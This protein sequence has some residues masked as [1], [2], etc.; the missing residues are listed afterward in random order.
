[1]TDPDYKAFEDLVKASLVLF[2]MLEMTNYWTVQTRKHNP[3][4]GA[5]EVIELTITRSKIIPPQHPV[6]DF[7]GVTGYAEGVAV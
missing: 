5:D 6:A 4:I 2:V 7:A 1:M 3:E